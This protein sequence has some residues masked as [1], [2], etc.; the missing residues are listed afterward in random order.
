LPNKLQSTLDSQLPDIN[1]EADFIKMAKENAKYNNP[2]SAMIAN[3]FERRFM[4]ADID[5]CIHKVYQTYNNTEVKNRLIFLEVKMKDE[6]VK[7]GNNNIMKILAEDFNWSKYDYASGCFY[8]KVLDLEL[9]QFKVFKIE[10]KDG[11]QIE[12]YEGMLDRQKLNDW[13][14]GYDVKSIIHP[15]SKVFKQEFRLDDVEGLI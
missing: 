13:F 5:M 10:M 15:Y 7:F 6:T 8:L 4:C 12:R 14:C 9:T 2:V 3:C 1:M 11:K